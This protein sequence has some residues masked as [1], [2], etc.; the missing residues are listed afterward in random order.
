M[1]SPLALLGGAGR[2]RRGTGRRQSPRRRLLL[3]PPLP[4]LPLVLLPRGVEDRDGGVSGPTGAE[5]SPGTAKLRLIET[6]P[7]GHPRLS[8]LGRSSAGQSPRALRGGQPGAPQ[9]DTRVRGWHAR[10]LVTLRSPCRFFRSAQ[11]DRHRLSP[12]IIASA[13]RAPGLTSICGW[14][15]AGATWRDPTPSHSSLGG[16]VGQQSRGSVYQTQK[17]QAVASGVPEAAGEVA[18]GS[19]LFPFHLLNHPRPMRKPDRRFIRIYWLRRN[20]KDEKDRVHQLCSL[21]PARLRQTPVCTRVAAVHTQSEALKTGQLQAQFNMRGGNT[22]VSRPL[23]KGGGCGC[24]GAP[25]GPCG[26]PVFQTRMRAAK[27]LFRASQARG[28][29]VVPTALS[30]VY[31]LHTPGSCKDGFS[32]T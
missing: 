27:L 11:P 13:K 31:P 5:G 9:R 21:P 19:F 29:R 10:P 16:W 14:S 26:S 24:P 12:A 18:V 28:H 8:E 32:Q 20:L 23:S 17:F 15:T 7:L 3:L 1:P 30:P 2:R 6:A 25:S 4:L 22:W